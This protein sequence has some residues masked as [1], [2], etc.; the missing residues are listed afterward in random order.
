MPTESDSFHMAATG[1]GPFNFEV[2]PFPADHTE[3]LSFEGD[4]D[5]EAGPVGTSPS[6]TV[7]DPIVAPQTWLALPTIGNGPFGDAGAGTVNMH[8]TATAHTRPFDAAVTSA[9]G[10][11]LLAY[12]SANAPAA[13]PVTVDVGAN[14]SIQVTITPAG[15][16]GTVVR[17]TLFLDAIDPL[18]GS[19]DEIAALPCAYTIS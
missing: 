2:S 9:T 10:D 17:G 19:T 18:T 14:G 3:D 1:D 12:V 8:F 13:T 4:P 6:V 7:S 15:A 5:R 16:K 11:P